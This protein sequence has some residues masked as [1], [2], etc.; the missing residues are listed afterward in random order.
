M[1]TS[2]C[3]QPRVRE[4]LDKSLKTAEN[5]RILSKSD[6]REM[7]TRILNS[8]VVVMRLVEAEA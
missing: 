3:R 7:L 5:C 4:D 1:F 6:D 2:V 8:W